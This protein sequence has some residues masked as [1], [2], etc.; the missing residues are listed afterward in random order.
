MPPQVSRATK[1]RRRLLTRH[2]EIRPQSIWE[3]KAQALKKNNLLA[4]HRGSERFDALG[5]LSNLKEFCRRALRPGQS[6]KPR[7]VLLLGVPGSGKSCFAKA[8]GNDT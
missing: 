8:L 5:G 6:V 2:N 4:L 7:G 1:Q 3:L